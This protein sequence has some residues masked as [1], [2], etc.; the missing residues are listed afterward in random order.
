MRLRF[1]LLVVL[2]RLISEC[3]LQS[4]YS[5]ISFVSFCK[6]SLFLPT[7]ITKELITITAVLD[8]TS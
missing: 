1:I 8:I 7:F 3:P 5:F 2:I 4:K 6:Q